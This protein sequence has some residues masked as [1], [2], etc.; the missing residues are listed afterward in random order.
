M[1]TTYIHQD[2]GSFQLTLQIASVQN[3]GKLALS[4]HG[5]RIVLI[6]VVDIFKVHSTVIHGSAGD[7]DDASWRG[8]FNDRQQKFREQVMGQ[9]IC[10]KLHASILSSVSNVVG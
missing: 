7:I 5:P 6:L 10:G 1:C 8:L 2:A 9:V 3:I 4:V